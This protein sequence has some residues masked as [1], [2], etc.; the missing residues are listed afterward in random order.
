MTEFIPKKNTCKKTKCCLRRSQ[1]LFL[2]TINGFS[3]FWCKEYIQCD[4][5]IDHLVMSMCR[6]VSCIV[7]RGCLIW[8]V[9]FLG[10]TQLAFR[11]FILYFNVKLAVIPGI[12][13]LPTFSLQ[14]A[15]KKKTFFS[16]ISSRRS[17]MSSH[18]H[19][20]WT[21]LALLVGT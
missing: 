14:Y 1:V 5:D 3:I 7:G 16:V 17:Y 15:M 11:C 12:S 10:K 6:V 19:L 13:W 9:C 4:F 20:I 21:S 18:N 8:P 2:L